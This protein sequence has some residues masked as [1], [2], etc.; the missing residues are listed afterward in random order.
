MNQLQVNQ[1]HCTS[2]PVLR[3]RKPPPTPDAVSV[4]LSRSQA[5]GQS[6]KQL[7]ECARE[8]ALVLELL[9]QIGYAGGARSA[10]LTSQVAPTSHF[11]PGTL[12]KSSEPEPDRPG[13]A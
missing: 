9:P 12:Q 8:R 6:S 7:L 1:P 2:A 13:F 4:I 5:L 11:T 10:L 3:N